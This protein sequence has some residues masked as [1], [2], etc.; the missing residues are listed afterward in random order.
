MK[1]IFKLF[2]ASGDEEVDDEEDDDDEDMS[3]S[4]VYNDNLGKNLLYSDD[5]RI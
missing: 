5:L 1:I 4:A 2:L 3:L